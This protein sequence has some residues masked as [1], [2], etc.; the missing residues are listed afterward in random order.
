MKST[1]KRF[2]LRAINKQ[3]QSKIQSYKDKHVGEKAVI[4]C[5]G[6]SLL[7]TDFKLL[8]QDHIKVFGLNKINLL[9][10]DISDLVDY[11]CVCN[12]FVIEQNREYYNTTDIPTFV[13][14]AG[15]LKLVKLRENIISLLGRDNHDFSRE[16]TEGYWQGH[17]VT[18]MA[19]QV[20]YYMGFSEVA[21]IGCD[22]SFVEK[23]KANSKVQTV[24]GDSSHFIKGYFKE[25][26]T[27][28]LPDLPM[29]EVSYLRARVDYS[30]SDRAL[31]N[32][33]DGGML[34]LLERMPLEQFV[35]EA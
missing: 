11:I 34:E 1:L 4:L 22:H 35:K 32:C 9:R 25:G 21:V 23:G 20:A 18:Y 19:M 10:E 16:L 13:D 3:Q 33:T 5:N 6:P 26:D 12:R 14:A 28:Q 7:K 15:T 8:K 2:I 24:G 27:W 17:T 29:S 31:Y 30:Y